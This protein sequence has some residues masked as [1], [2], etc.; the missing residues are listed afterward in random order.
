MFENLLPD[1]DALCRR[2][3]ERVGAGGTDAYSLLAAIGRDC[4]GALQFLGEGDLVTDDW[5]NLSGEPV[6]E[7]AIEKILLN[8]S[9]APLGLQRDDD[10]RISIAGAQ[11]KTALLWCG[12]QWI[13]PHGTTPTTHLFKTPIGQFS[14]GMDL[15]GSVENEYFCLRLLKALGFAVNDAEVRTFGRAKALVVTRFDRAWEGKRLIRLPQEDCCQALGVP[16]AR[17]YQSEGG[18]GVSDIAGLL[19][20]ADSPREDQATLFKAQLVFWLLGATDGHAKNFSIFLRP[21]GR[22]ALTPLYDV[23]SVQP[24]LDRRQIERK[25][26]K[27]AMALGNKNHY[28]VDDIQARHFVQ[29]AGRAGVPLELVQRAMASVS[30]DIDAALETVA[31]ELPDGFPGALQDSISNGVRARLRQL[32]LGLSAT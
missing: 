31:G 11:G 10:F 2:V 7:A 12:G 22:Y 1:S 15:S 3:A 20:G 17:K 5:G 26:M 21:G 28:R 19:K 18:P 25:Q 8:L 32:N 27:M 14:N 23:L 30:G 4:V 24:T 29:S 13:K 6:D 16:P 9:V